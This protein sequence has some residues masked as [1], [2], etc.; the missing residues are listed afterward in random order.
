MSGIGRQSNFATDKSNY[1]TP[2]WHDNSS[3]QSWA[4]TP[5]AY[6][7]NTSRSYASPNGAYTNFSN[8]SS[9]TQGFT[10][11][12]PGYTQYPI[13]NYHQTSEPKTH[14]LPYSNTS[15]ANNHAFTQKVAVSRPS[16]EELLSTVGRSVIL[17][18]DS[19]SI[20]TDLLQLGVTPYMRINST[21][22][23][24][25][26]QERLSPSMLF[27]LKLNVHPLNVIQAFEYTTPATTTTRQGL[28]FVC[29]GQ[30]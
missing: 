25:G 27:W 9:A 30:N 8:P 26:K 14:Q 23:T 10:N 1:Y 2:D 18:P 22:N 12:Y 7:N 5:P 6:S 3:V 15:N 24:H 28:S 16:D 19:T 17:R 21:L 11:Q 20:P 29:Y 13:G 4:N